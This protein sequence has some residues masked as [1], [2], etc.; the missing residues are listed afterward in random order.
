MKI[1]DHSPTRFEERDALAITSIT[2]DPREPAWPLDHVWLLG[3]A[4]SGPDVTS[5]AAVAAKTIVRYAD[6]LSWAVV[7]AVRAAAA[8]HAER[9]SRSAENVALVHVTPSGPA[10]TMARVRQDA[11]AG[12]ASPIRF[13]AA[14][15]SAPAGLA[16]LAFGLRGPSLC[17]AMP[18]EQGTTI[19]LGMA[20]AWLARRTADLCVIVISGPARSAIPRA[21]CVLLA[22]ADDVA[23][24]PLAIVRRTLFDLLDSP[25]QEPS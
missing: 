21:A 1:V 15:P 8:P 16:C 19:A 2:V 12:F 17:L 14:A 11:A 18:I 13:P 25:Q 5:P 22:P 3:A 24:T 10:E 20:A 23:T 6:P 4:A 7:A 9:M